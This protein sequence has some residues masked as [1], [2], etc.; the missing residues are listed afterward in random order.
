MWLSPLGSKANVFYKMDISCGVATVTASV[1]VGPDKHSFT[2][3]LPLSDFWGGGAWS[4]S[5]SYEQSYLI[6][7]IQV[8]SQPGT[9]AHAEHA[10]S[11]FDRIT[12]PFAVC[13]LLKHTDD[14]AQICLPSNKS[15][16]LH[17]VCEKQFY[18]LTIDTSIT[19]WVKI[20]LSLQMI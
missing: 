4:W 3:S 2:H 17:N 9:K 12:L 8:L 15:A 10:S 5:D 1:L 14:D 16:Y 20:S 13:V 18:L 11:F 19:K 6:L 7:S